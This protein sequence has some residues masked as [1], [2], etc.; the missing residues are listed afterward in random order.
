MTKSEQREV[1]KLTAY[2]GHIDDAVIAAGISGLIRAASAKSRAALIEVAVKLGVTQ[3][4][5]YII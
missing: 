3:H 2:K 4:P 5:D 1:A